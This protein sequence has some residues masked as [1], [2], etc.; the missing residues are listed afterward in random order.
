M[1]S[2][3]DE[4]GDPRPG[5]VRGLHTEA[6]GT[7][8]R[9]WEDACDRR[10]GTYRP[11]GERRCGPRAADTDTAEG[12]FNSSLSRLLPQ[13]ISVKG[14][15]RGNVRQWKQVSMGVRWRPCRDMYEVANCEAGQG[16]RGRGIYLFNS[17]QFLRG[18][19][20]ELRFGFG[21]P[22]PRLGRWA[23]TIEDIEEPARN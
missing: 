9:E 4:T 11:T 7:A 15:W 17:I 19:R 13:S 14:F 21:G 22:R 16:G 5:A 10:E 2:E 8:S 6:C 20:D 1:V 12:C 18:G 23:G 3:R